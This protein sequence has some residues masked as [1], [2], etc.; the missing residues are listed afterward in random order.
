MVK[1]KEVIVVKKE[2]MLQIS[3]QPEFKAVITEVE[4]GIF[5]IGLP[6]LDG[7]ILML[8][9]NQ[10]LKIRIPMRY[11]FYSAETELVA[12]GENNKKFYGLAIP[13]DFTKTQ[14]RQYV[15]A[16]HT[17]SVT[18]TSGS[19]SVQ[20]ALVNFSAGGLMVYLTPPLERILESGNDI[21]IS[22]QVEDQ[23]F[24]LNACLSWRKSYDNI[25]YA[26]FEFS[27]ILPGIQKRL[28]MAALR[29]TKMVK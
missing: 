12:V 26:G 27:Y 10:K 14:E 20:T 24:R 2:V 18:F 15:R 17:T 4:E 29:Y 7:Q 13:E 6:R 1:A 9:K 22:F 28:D 11:G 3:N 8:Q 19:V 23:M 16:F 21:V 25:P 5:W